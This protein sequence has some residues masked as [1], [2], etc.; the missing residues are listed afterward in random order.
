ERKRTHTVDEPY[1]GAWDEHPWPLAMELSSSLPQGSWSL[2]GGLMIKA[3]AT[4]HGFDH[5]RITTDVDV[6]DLRPNGEGYTTIASRLREQGFVL[7][8]NTSLAYR[9]IREG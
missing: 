5:P 9:F 6:L 2:V 3:R 4:I 8:E 1:S 7:A